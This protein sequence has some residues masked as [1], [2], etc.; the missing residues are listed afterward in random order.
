MQRRIS[1][2]G[3]AGNR[4]RTYEIFIGRKLQLAVFSVKLAFYPHHRI[5][6]SRCQSADQACADKLA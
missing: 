5:A 1:N 6:I 2:I 4:N 3:L